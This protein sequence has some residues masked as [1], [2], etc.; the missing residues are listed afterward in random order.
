MASRKICKICGKIV[1]VWSEGF[2]T[3]NKDNW[4]HLDCL[5]KEEL[6]D[7]RKRDS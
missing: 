5:Y 1:K 7:E 2:E 6:K 3:D 4:W